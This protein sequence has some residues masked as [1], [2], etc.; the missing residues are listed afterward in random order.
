MSTERYRFSGILKNGVEVDMGFV[1]ATESEIQHVLEIVAKTYRDGEK[2]YLA[3]NGGI[4]NTEEFVAVKH[5]KI[6]VED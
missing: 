1:N 5:R 4:Y 2:S 6:I 3:I